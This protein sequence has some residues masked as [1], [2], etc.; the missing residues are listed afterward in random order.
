MIVCCC[1]HWLFTSFIN[2]SARLGP[3]RITLG[4][5]PVT[6][7]LM[8]STAYLYNLTMPHWTPSPVPRGTTVQQVLLA[9]NDLTMT[10][11]DR[12]LLLRPLYYFS[13]TVCYH[14]LICKRLT[15]LWLWD[16]WCFSGT[17]INWQSCPSGS[18][19]N[20]QG[21]SRSSQCVACEGGQYCQGEHLTAPTANCSAGKPCPMHW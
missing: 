19:S 10:H 3:T 15:C 9:T 21:L 18:Y 8:A 2:R 11:F 4:P 13:P 5:L 1:F 14:R 7:V 16:A 20:Q 12:I 17:G 6:P